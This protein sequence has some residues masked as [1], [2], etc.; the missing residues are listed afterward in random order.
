MK[1]R[2]GSATGVSGACDK[3]ADR[4]RDAVART[5]LERGPQN[6]A[7]LAER[8]GLSPAGIRRHLDAL[9][10]DGFLA[11]REP[12]PSASRGRGRP[13]RT[14]ALTDA[15]RAAFPHA[16]DDLAN[17]ALR[18]LRDTGGDDAVTAFAEHRAA[19]LAADVRDGVDCAQPLADRSE[20]L[21]GALTAHGYAST[22]QAVRDADDTIHG[23]QICQHHCPVAHVAAEFPQLCEAETR[24]FEQV[25][26]T[27][28][29]RLATIAHG[30]GVCTTHIPVRPK[31][32][33]PTKGSQI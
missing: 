11:E 28:V 10:A 24:A 9:V 8:L 32:P 16:Y 5:I 19:T 31:N 23:I 6:A 4:T 33:A 29:Q 12:R 21:A 2:A 17:T 18:Y 20:A 25:L 13:A 7:H 15:G 27:Y 3:P 1:I 30:D 22:V 26:G 14:Y